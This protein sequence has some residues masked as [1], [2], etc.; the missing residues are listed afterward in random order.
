M[1]DEDT[2]IDEDGDDVI[3]GQR[4]ARARPGLLHSR[5]SWEHCELTGAQCL[6]KN[7][8]HCHTRKIDTVTKII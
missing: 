5:R 1:D 6:G 2:D 4:K 3:C 8:H 7:N